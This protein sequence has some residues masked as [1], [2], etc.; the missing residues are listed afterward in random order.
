[1]TD[2][3][4]SYLRY[5]SYEDETSDAGVFI[6]ETVRRDS[7][8]ELLVELEENDEC[9]ELLSENDVI[10]FSKEIVETSTEIVVKLSD[11]TILFPSDKK[12]SKKYNLLFSMFLPDDI[13][14]V[15]SILSHLWKGAVPD[16]EDEK[17][18]LG[19]KV[20]LEYVPGNL[21]KLF[22]IP[23]NQITIAA[24]EYNLLCCFKSKV[25]FIAHN[26]FFKEWT[27]NELS[28][29]TLDFCDT[30]I[31][32]FQNYQDGETPEGLLGGHTL[33]DYKVEAE[34]MIENFED[35]GIEIPRH[36]LT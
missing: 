7:I 22:R 1:V 10:D 13:D 21:A 29:C 33:E 18:E 4:V 35:A 30:S 16:T 34:I 5:V 28:L 11:G 2:F 15:E 8:E 24:T 6:N 36:E 31:M 17:F 25:H 3:L 20:L 27:K 19:K 23:E 12:D 14:M 26:E 32:F 9:L